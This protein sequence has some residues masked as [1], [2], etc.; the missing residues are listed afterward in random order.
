M[1]QAIA[2]LA[3]LLLALSTVVRADNGGTDVKS[4]GGNVSNGAGEPVISGKY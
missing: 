2:L 3:V 1:K 4:E